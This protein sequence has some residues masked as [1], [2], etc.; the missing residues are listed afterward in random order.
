MF[1]GKRSA[2]AIERRAAKKASRV[3]EKNEQKRQIFG[4]WVCPNEE[5]NNTNFA[6]R[7]ACNMCGTANPFLEERNKF[8]QKQPRPSKTS[9]KRN[10]T[11]GMKAENVRLRDLLEA[12]KKSGITCKELSKED[13]KR[14]SFLLSKLE[15]ERKKKLAKRKRAELRKT[16]ENGSTEEPTYDDN[17]APK[18][19]KRVEATEGETV[20]AT[21][22]VTV[23]V[24]GAEKKNKKEK[25]DKKSKNEKEEKVEEP[26]P[27]SLPT[28]EE[29]AEAK[30]SK[31]DKKDKAGDKDGKDCTSKSGKKKKSKKGKK[32]SSDI[33]GGA[34]DQE[35]EAVSEEKKEKKNKKNKK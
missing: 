18:K 35:D 29:K 19:K 5:C 24:D 26:L 12:E 14:A 10:P 13:R 25:K 8:S 1:S 11:D 6:R 22:I 23:A 9:W 32:H 16:Q 21:E 30:K 17:A 7:D 20:E 27:L 15:A 2:A 34:S 3:E 28:E 33:G 4:D 31:K